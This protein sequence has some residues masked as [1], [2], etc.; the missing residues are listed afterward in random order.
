MGIT[1]N[2]STTEFDPRAIVRR[3][4][5][6]LTP[7][8]LEI[9][10]LHFVEGRSQLL[11]ADWLGIEGRTVRLHIKNAGKKIPQ[12]RRLRIQS[13]SKIER[14]KILHLSQL[15]PTERGPFNADEV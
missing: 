1:L 11:I 4:L 7:R 3:H 14:P 5:E 13:K 9:C 15:R 8:E 6:K 12:L 10:V 2:A